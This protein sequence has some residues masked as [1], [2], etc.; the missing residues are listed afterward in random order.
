MK[1]KRRIS[2]NNNSVA[3]SLAVVTAGAILAVSPL[4]HLGDEGHEHKLEPN[5]GAGG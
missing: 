3:A 2:T 5:E 4:S 1:T